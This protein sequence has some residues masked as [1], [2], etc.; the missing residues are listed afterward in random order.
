MKNTIIAI[1]LTL[2]L[3]PGTGHLYLKKFRRAFL[4][5]A[6]ALLCAL[7]LAL[8]VV[9]AFSAGITPAM[10]SKEATLLFQQFAAS[11]PNTMLFYDALLAALWAYALLDVYWQARELD[12]AAVAKTQPGEEE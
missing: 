6:G 12:A 7:L 5:I 11:S 1:A 2:L 4:F 9:K 8:Q 3:G 10:G